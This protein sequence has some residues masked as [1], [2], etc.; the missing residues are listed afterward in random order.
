MRNFA[1]AVASAITIALL[2]GC[3]NFYVVPAVDAEASVKVQAALPPQTVV[4]IPMPEDVEEMLE[5][6]EEPIEDEIVY[7][8]LTSKLESEMERAAAERDGH[9]YFPEGLNEDTFEFF[10]NEDIPLPRDVQEAVYNACVVYDLDPML[11]YA[12]IWQETTWRNIK[13]PGDGAG[14]MQVIEKWHRDR[15]KRVGATNLMNPADNIMVGCDYLAYNINKYGLAK[16]LG[17]Y[18]TGS[19]VVNGYSKSVM[20]RYNKVWEGIYQ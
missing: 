11:I 14:Y 7:D 4:V 17:V 16:G 13:T 3:L 8:E 18:N 10:Y 9:F 12:V 15:M 19:A 5:E 6:F 1:T 2:L 20:N